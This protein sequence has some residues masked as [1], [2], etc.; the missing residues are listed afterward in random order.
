P[1]TIVGIKDSGCEREWSL[2]LAKAFM[3][4][5]QVWVGNEPDLQVMAVQGT[6]GA[7]SG[8][9]NVT[10]RLVA[11][12]VAQPAGPHAARD[13]ARVQE[14]LKILFGYGLTATFKGVMAILTGHAGWRRVRAPLV[15]LTDAEF[16]ALQ[17]QMKAFALDPAL[18]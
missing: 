5:L 8:V 7:V 1:Q 12:M 9:A 17:G 2:G 3:P 14:L 4:P 10:P 18:D 11:R 16:A 6:M 13:M 15:A